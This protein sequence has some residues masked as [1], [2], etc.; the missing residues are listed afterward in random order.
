VVPSTWFAVVLFV[1]LVAPGLAFDLWS[2]RRRVGVA[3]SAFREAG[4]VVLASLVFSTIGLVLVFAVQAWTPRLM[5]DL[6]RLASSKDAS[7]AVQHHWRVLVAIAI[8]AIGSF[9]TAAIVHCRLSRGKPKLRSVSAWTEIFR[10]DCP[11]GH[12]PQ[13]RVRLTDGTIYFGELSDFTHDLDFGDREL[14]LGPPL[15]SRASG[16]GKTLKA[17]D[18]QWERVVVHGPSIAAVTVRYFPKPPDN[19]TAP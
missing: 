8:F 17:M 1:L 15:Y 10:N 2:A 13:L 11:P 7:Y 12:N 16:E 19:Q 14:V 9:G 18:E 3:E 4:R 6:P 5:P